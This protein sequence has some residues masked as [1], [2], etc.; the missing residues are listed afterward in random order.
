MEEAE[1]ETIRS[2]ILDWYD[3]V[4]YTRLEKNG[5]VLIVMTRWH[6]DDL[7]GQL[8]AR[9]AAN[10]LAD[11]WEVVS[12]PAILDNKTENDPR[13]EGE[14]LW[15]NKYPIEELSKIKASVGSRIFSSLYQQA[16][17]NK[18]GGLIKRG[19]IKYYDILPGYFDSWTISLDA[20]F[21]ESSTSDFVVFQVWARKGGEYYLVD[22]IRDRMNF[23]TTIQTFQNLC[24][25]YPKATAKLVEVKANGQAI[26]DTLKH[27]ISGII[28][29]IPKESKEARLS[30]VAPLFEAGNIYLPTNKQFT[31]DFV[32]ELCGFPFMKHDDCVD[33]CSQ[34]LNWAR[35]N[36]SG[37]FKM[38]LI[39]R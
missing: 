38:G 34:M 39:R 28:E 18:E 32:E 11:Q 24:I 29:I 21:K 22:Q 23:P 27:D 10:P 26:V 30:A 4:A 12:F 3:S 16:P 31:Y 13:L 5:S 35:D 20:T 1:S 6:Q 17:T 9:A 8:L 14:A 7:C 25:V 33:C 15:P 2:K 37:Y 36:G 19:W